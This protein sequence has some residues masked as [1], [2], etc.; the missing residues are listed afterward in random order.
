MW[1]HYNTLTAVIRRYAEYGGFD[2]RR[3]DIE[4]SIQETATQSDFISKSLGTRCILYLSYLFA[5]HLWPLDFPFVP[6]RR[7]GEVA[8]EQA[9]AKT[10]HERNGVE[11]VGIAASGVDPQVVECRPQESRV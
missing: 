11:K 6:E 3:P 9:L 10:P 1:L 2:K 4:K 7:K 5:H 8:D